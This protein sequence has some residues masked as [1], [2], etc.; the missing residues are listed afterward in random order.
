MTPDE[1][2]FT[3]LAILGAAACLWI[4]FRVSYRPDDLG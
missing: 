1:I 4:G 3:V 2:A